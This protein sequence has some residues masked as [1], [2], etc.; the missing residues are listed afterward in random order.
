MINADHACAAVQR[1]RLPGDLLADVFAERA[2]TTVVEADG[3]GVRV[4]RLEAR[5]GVGVRATAGHE[6]RYRYTP[7]LSNAGVAAVSRA[8]HDRCDVEA[9]RAAGV[10]PPS[11]RDVDELADLARMAL[12]G[13]PGTPA[14]GSVTVTVT[15]RAVR[16]DVVVVR[17]DG[18]VARD[19]R[20]YC[21]LRVDA[22]VA[23]LAG[24]RH[25]RRTVGAGRA[26]DLRALD[27]TRALVPDT[28]R[29]AVDLRTPAEPPTGTMPVVFGPGKPAT[30][31]HEA[32]GHLLEAD[33]TAEPQSVF[34]AA[35]GRQIAA[36]ALTLVDGDPPGTGGR[37]YAVDDEGEPAR[38]T[39]II[40]GGV[41]R[42]YLHDR[43]TA[44]LT[45]RT[46]TGNGRRLSYRYPPLPRM[47][48]TW[49]APGTDTRDE[50]IGAV[51]RGLLVSSISGGTVDMGSGHYAVTADEVH[52]IDNGRVGAPVPAVVL[53][54][55]ASQLLGS[56]D[57]VADD[58]RRV[59]FG[60]ACNK[61]DQYPLYV[62]V[63][64][65]SIRVSAHEVTP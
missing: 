40:A 24:R 37:L 12:D 56:I 13:G 15:A 34:H 28:V 45:G 53:R 54:G 1:A 35:I 23:T 41:L 4:T 6:T 46:P 2:T 47:S 8:V 57:G 43:R 52:R 33:V 19:T 64:A 20:T 60:Y 9:P 25:L 17:C 11:L 14:D 39:E 16:Q 30:L 31:F 59:P 63:G 61:L 58:L 10:R 50:L 55:H 26:S 5:H 29:A 27:A 38:R 42:S 18:V 32:C 48:S 65:P 62:S 21:G 22:T 36:P 51:G 49:V 7:D 44:A 3:G